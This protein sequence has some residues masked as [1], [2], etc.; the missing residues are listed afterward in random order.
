MKQSGKITIGFLVFAALFGIALDAA[1]QII[2]IYMN[3]LN[4][5]NE[6]ESRAMETQQSSVDNGEKIR[7]ELM[8]K[9][10]EYHIPLA[11]ES[12]LIDFDNHSTHIKASWSVEVKFLGGY[13]KRP[14]SFVAETTK[15]NL[16]S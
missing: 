16:R 5:K 13:Y 4:F 14:V 3:Y 15:V 2:P 7:G 9:A 1:F 6:V 8:K 12:L 11:D 10:S